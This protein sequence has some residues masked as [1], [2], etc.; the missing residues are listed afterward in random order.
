MWNIEGL[1]NEKINDTQFQNITSKFSIISFVETWLGDSSQGITL[2]NF[3][4]VH[5]SS[6]KKHRKAR[7]HSGGICIFAKNC[8][9][10]GIVQIKNSHPDILW[11]KLDHTFFKLH[12][13]IYL[14]VV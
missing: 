13:D 7:R 2:D 11:I 10:K 4:L 1:R 12:K 3:H 8:I 14:A 9:K 6:R 5:S